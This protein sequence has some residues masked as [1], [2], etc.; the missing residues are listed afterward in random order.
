MQTLERP[1][2]RQDLVAEPI[3]DGASRFIDVADPDSGN[4]YRFY[5]VEYSLACAMDGERDVAGIVKWAEEELG[6]K[7]SAKEVRSVIATLGDLGYLESGAAAAAAVSAAAASAEAPPPAR[8][9]PVEAPRAAAPAAARSKTPAAGVVKPD[10]ELGRGVVT[11][12]RS[13]GGATK[14]SPDVELGTAGGRAPAPAE[15]LPSGGDFELGAPGANTGA[16]Q[17]AAR[18]AGDDFALGASGAGAGSSPAL[19]TD[20]AADMAI[21]TADVKEAVRAS[22]VMKSVDIPPELAAELEPPKPVEAPKAAKPAEAPKP[23]SASKPVET[24]PAEAKPQAK[25]VDLPTER[26]VLPKAPPSTGTSPILIGLLVLVV[27]AAGAFFVY[28]LVL[29]KDAPQKKVEAPVAPQPPQPPVPPPAETAKLATEQPDAV[30][31]KP[32]GPATIATIV[33]TDSTVKAGEPIA[34][35]AGYKPISVEVEALQKSVDKTKADIAKATQ[36]RD[37]AQTAGNKAGVTAAETKLAGFEKSLAASEGKLATKVAALDAFL[38]KAPAAGKITAVAKPNA[39][40]TPTDIIATLTRDPITVATFKSAGEVAPDTRVLLAISGSEQK[41]SCTVV[42]TGGDG[43][44]IACPQDA[45]PDGTEVTYAGVDPSVPAPSE[46]NPDGADGS[47]GSADGSAADDAD[48]SAA[49]PAEEAPE[50]PV[51]KKAH[52]KK[53]PAPR[54]QPKAA[55]P[56]TPAAPAAPAG[57]PAPTPAKAEPAPAPAGSGT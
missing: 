12:A 50:A 43:T 44:K 22:Q 15:A 39:K 45:A 7:P 51:E 34:R 35:L 21:S 10:A 26:P 27:L 49:A 24:K 36:D 54:P 11:G 8:P 55:K 46:T 9:E 25:P 53:A 37:A 17:P 2:F 38:I 1:R 52:A 13:T 31:I 23:A 28:K 16:K 33:S 18:K 48:G 40:V 4:L 42:A 29:N 3:E 14:S 56:A 47:A 5:E 57:E 41:L 32:A 6:L 30:D 19:S 20:L